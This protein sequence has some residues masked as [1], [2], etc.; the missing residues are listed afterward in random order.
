MKKS[1]KAFSIIEVVTATVILSIAVFWVFKL[2]SENHKIIN[3][4]DD[5][6]TATSLFS[7]FKE[8]MEN[9]WSWTLNNQIFYINLNNCTKSNTKI[10][11]IINNKEYSLYWS[12]TW[13]SK[14]DLY[15]KND[16]LN[17]KQEYILNN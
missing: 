17:L 7:P 5:Y 10:Y 12:W 6:N 13:D 9:I 3:N 14:F 4:S 11:N 8:C 16:V 15:I 2:I 1:R